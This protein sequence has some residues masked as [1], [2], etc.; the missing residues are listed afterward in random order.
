MAVWL[1]HT[2][3][4]DGSKLIQSAP[5]VCG[6]HGSEMKWQRT[7]SQESFWRKKHRAIVFV[8][9]HGVG[10]RVIWEC[11]YFVFFVVVVYF[12]KLMVVDFAIL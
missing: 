12:D 2:S 9:W 6:W 5:S 11:I 1:F 3:C 8:D 7:R 10:I 4:V